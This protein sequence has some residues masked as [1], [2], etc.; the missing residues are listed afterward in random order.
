MQQLITGSPCEEKNCTE[1]ANWYV[2]RA[3]DSF[4]WC[5]KH[6]I[7]AMEEKDFWKKEVVILQHIAP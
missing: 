5:P 1:E 6:A 2:T 4:H 7:L 3:E